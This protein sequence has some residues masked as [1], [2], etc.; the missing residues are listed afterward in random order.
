MKQI[1]AMMICAGL[2]P[3]SVAVAQTQPKDSTLSRTVVVEN[4]YNPEVMDAFKVNVL[5]NVEEPAITKRSIEYA[6]AMHPLTAWKALPMDPIERELL[7]RSYGRGYARLA[8]GN[9]SNMDAKLSYLADLSS[10]DRLGVM[11]S[12]YGMNGKVPHWLEGNWQSRFFRGDIALD[13]KHD[14]RYVTLK[15][16]VNY[17]SQVFNYMP[18]DLQ[19]EPATTDKQHYT[20]AEGYIG[21]VSREG[22]DLP[23]SFAFQTGMRSFQRK[24]ELPTVTVGNIYGSQTGTESEFHTTGYIAANLDEA[25]QVGVALT[26]DNLLVADMDLQDYTLLQANPYYRYKNDIVDFRA[27]AHVDWQTSYDSGIRI[28]PDVRFA[29]TFADSY[30]F[31][32]Q[33]V[34]G[35]RLNDSRRLNEL[36]PYWM[37]LNQL[38]SSHTQVDASFGFKGSP[39]SGLGFKAYAGYR[40]TNDEVFVFPGYLQAIDGGQA[41]LSTDYLYSFLLPDKAKVAYGGA[42]VNYAYKDWF[43]LGAHG[44]FYDWKVSDGFDPLLLLKPQFTLDLSARVKIFKGLHV[45]GAYRYVKRNKVEGVE[46][47]AINNVSVSG[48]YELLNH[49]NV[50]VRFNNLLNKKYTEENGYSAQRF[51][52]LAGISCRF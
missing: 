32:A 51:N 8:Y 30:V 49:V 3:A 31:F 5:P 20:A 43:D 13:Y 10:K 19:A 4:Q 39:V 15:L 2:L 46:A 44:V 14:F 45:G 38:T 34:G 37:Q 16:G 12:L 47:N 1:E 9:R 35:S 33:A 24:Y 27:G 21:V 18:S 42:E 29:C 26:M 36:T 23:V 50:F 11:A 17:A 25:Q 52:A 48:E 6:T 22:E 28:A 40:I 7:Q 41:A